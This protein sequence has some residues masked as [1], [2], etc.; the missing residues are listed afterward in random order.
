MP[1]LFTHIPKTAGT[2]FKMGVISPNVAPE[3]IL[4][5]DGIRG[6]LRDR[7]KPFDFLEGHYPYGVHRLIPCSAV[8][9]YITILREPL[10]RAISNYYFVKQCDTPD[11]QH[12]DLDDAKHCDLAGFSALPRFQNLQ[13]KYTAGLLAMKLGR[14]L[15]GGL[16]DQLLLARAKYHL[17]KKYHLFGLTERMPE[18]EQMFAARMGWRTVSLREKF[19]ATQA[20]PRIAD[21]GETTKTSVLRSNRLDVQLYD[22]AQKL[23][24]ARVEQ[25]TMAHETA[26][27]REG[28]TTVIPCL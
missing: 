16:R 3:R 21:L 27:P 10:D 22:F 13:T 8:F 28:P 2:S 24:A 19:K 1:L 11:Y 17:S 20:R 23:F 25:F 15:P 14:C 26:A 7:H 12:P 4:R 6:L 5:F 9:T 18:F